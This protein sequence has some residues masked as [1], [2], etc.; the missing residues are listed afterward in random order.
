MRLRSIGLTALSVRLSPET[1]VFRPRVCFSLCVHAC[2][3]SVSCMCVSC[4]CVS[5][6]AAG[7]GGWVGG[8]GLILS[9]I[10]TEVGLGHINI[11][12]NMRESIT[13]EARA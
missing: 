1:A 9:C 8:G 10:S 12:I 4:V 6:V 5:A 3:S 2:M 7:V 13:G 11:L